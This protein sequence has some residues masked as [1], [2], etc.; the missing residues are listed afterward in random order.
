MEDREI[1]N[2]EFQD[3]GGRSALRKATKFNP[4]IYPFP[5]CG[6]PDRLTAADKERGYQC[7][8]CADRD[9]GCGW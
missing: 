4:R 7:N 3:P 6:A 5:T 1:R 9:E 8:R 2:S